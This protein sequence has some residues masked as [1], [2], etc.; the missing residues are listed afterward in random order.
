MSYLT[1][2]GNWAKIFSG[3]SATLFTYELPLLEFDFVFNEILAS[4]PIPFPPLAW[5]SIDIG[6]IGK[7]SAFVDLSFGFDTFGV[8]K[9]IASG[10]ALDVVD[11]FYVNDWTLPAFKNGQVVPGTGGKE[12]P[13][14]GLKLEAGLLGGIGI[15]GIGSAG[16]GGS[17][18][19]SINAD[20]N[21][22]M[23][24][25]IA[26]DANGQVSSVNYV[27]DGRIRASEVLAMVLYPGLIPGIPGGPLNLFDLTLQG[28]VSPYIWGR[29]LLTG[30]MTFKLFELKLPALTL[31]AP[32]VIPELGNV[33]NGVLTLNMGTRASD[34][35]FLTTE[36]AAES[37]I[38]S[39]ADAG[40]V[41]VDAHDPLL[42]YGP[43]KRFSTS[44]SGSGRVRIGF[45]SCCMFRENPEQ[46]IWSVFFTL[47]HMD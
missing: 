18:A 5:I 42:A 27:G 25:K 6:V 14:F 13:E 19:L 10:N 11:G 35:L 38:L 37:V 3:G 16:V 1:D 12:K 15:T 22:I 30:T 20:M 17:I 34:R 2:I 26:R 31:N 7:V 23:T 32:T 39:G 24:G 47:L 28:S 45:G 8:Q 29:T 9:A 40:V 4:I 36:D 44:P 33:K 21:D 46:P 41:D 43:D